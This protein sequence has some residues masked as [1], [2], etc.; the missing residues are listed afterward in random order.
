MR[1]RGVAVAHVVAQRDLGREDP[2]EFGQV[3]EDAVFDD[4]LGQPVRMQERVVEAAPHRLRLEAD[5]HRDV[6]MDREVFVRD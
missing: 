5:L 4:V 3:G 6:D 2:R 1:V